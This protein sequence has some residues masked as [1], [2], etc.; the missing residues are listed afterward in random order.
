VIV[1]PVVS[2]HRLARVSARKRAYTAD[3]TNDR[4]ER[5]ASQAAPRPTRGGEATTTKRQK[6]TKTG[7]KVII[8]T[9]EEWAEEGLTSRG[10]LPMAL[11]VQLEKADCE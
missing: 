9:P 8:P 4:D 3:E 1:S 10:T 11:D 6:K 7:E 2:S 5:G